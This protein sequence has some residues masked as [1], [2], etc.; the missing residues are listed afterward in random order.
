MGHRHQWLRKSA[1]CLATIACIA[2]T[3]VEK[4]Q[5]LPYIKAKDQVIIPNHSRNPY[6]LGVRM[7]GAEIVEVDTPDELRA[8]ISPRTAMIYVMSGP[9]AAKDRLSI[10]A[11]LRHR[12]REG[13]SGVGRCGGGRAAQ[14]Q[15]HLARGA[16]LV[17]YS[18]G[19]CLRG[20]QSSGMLIGDKNLCKAAYF[21]AAPH[22]C[23]GRALK[24]SKEEAMGLLAAVEQW[25]KRDHA[26]EQRMWR[27]WLQTIE[28]RLKPL[29]STSF[30]YLEP[31]DLSNKATRLRVHWDAK[32]LRSPAPNWWPS[33]MP[34]RPRILVD[35]GTGRRPDQMASTF[36]IMPYMMDPGEDQHHRRRHPCR[37]DQSGSIIDDPPVPPGAP[38]AD[39]RRLGGDRVDYPR[40]EGEPIFTLTPERRRHHRQHKG[41]IYQR[42]CAARC[43][44]STVELRSAMVVPGNQY[45]LDLPR[46][47]QRAIA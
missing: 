16:T 10:A 29:P 21:Q 15:S 4:C 28:T 44:A 45:Q 36:T 32:V 33:W 23:Y 39:R 27:G 1:I 40:G 13:R 35:G 6:D 47:G 25:Y 14:A 18:G 2:G 31:D 11:H 42:P 37:S 5:A 7:V 30:E 20:P 17:G 12:Q 26:A 9:R 3:D 8:K 43:A 38:A 24:C 46:H 19:K 34:A 22:H 41:E